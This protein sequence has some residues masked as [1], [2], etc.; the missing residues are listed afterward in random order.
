MIESFDE[1]KAIAKENEGYAIKVCY[2]DRA[3]ENSGRSGAGQFCALCCRTDVRS[4]RCTF[5][6][7]V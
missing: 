6:S 5:L 2:A 4:E 1:Q 3:Q 7:F